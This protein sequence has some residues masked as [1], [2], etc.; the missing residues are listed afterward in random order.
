MNKLLE[1]F[2]ITDFR[3]ISYYLGISITWKE[4]SVR[5]G[6]KN[7]L[8]KILLWFEINTCKLSSLPMDPRV[9]NSILSILENQQ[10]DKDTIF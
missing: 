4:N 6:Q 10:I 2:Y 5:L 8:K 1:Y 3:S 7:Y 9:L